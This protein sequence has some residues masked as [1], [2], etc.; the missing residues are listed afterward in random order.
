MKR[1]SHLE[2]AERRRASTGRPCWPF[3]FLPL[4]RISFVSARVK[5]HVVGAARHQNGSIFRLRIVF[6]CCCCCCCCLNSPFGVRRLRLNAGTSRS[7]KTF[8]RQPGE[9]D[10]KY[11]R[12]RTHTHTHT[13]SQAEG[14][15]A[16]LSPARS[17]GRCR[18]F[19]T[20]TTSTRFFF[21]FNHD[22]K[23]A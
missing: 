19:T 14:S 12:Q 20:T 6:C 3:P 1:T 13:K 23:L 15:A 21:F 17:R 11:T 4:V 9:G 18:G 8:P 5:Q 22:T 2:A 7:T 16:H 10:E